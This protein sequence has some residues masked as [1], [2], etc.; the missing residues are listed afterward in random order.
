MKKNKQ[1]KTQYVLVFLVL[2]QYFSIN[3]WAEPNRKTCQIFIADKVFDGSILHVEEPMA[4]V[5]KKRRIYQVVP[6]STLNYNCKKKIDLG[7]ATIMPGLVESHAH[8]SFQNVD[9]TTVLR[10]GVTTA[11]DVGGP[12][13]PASG[14]IGSLRLVNTGPIIQAPGGYPLNL[15]GGHHKD[16]DHSDEGDHHAATIAVVAHD[17]KHAIEHVEHIANSGAVAIKVALE[18]GGEPGAP[19]TEGHGHGGGDGEGPPP[20]E[21]PV[22]PEEVLSAIV[23]KAHEFGLPVIAHVGEQT[24]FD[25]AVSAG[26][27]EFAHIPCAEVTQESITEAVA[28]GMRFQT[29]TNTLSGCLG[30]AANMHKILHAEAHLFDPVEA[31]FLYASEIG[32]DDVPWGFNGQ[33]AINLLLNFAGHTPVDFGHVL[34]V[35]KSATSIPGGLIGRQIGEPLLGTLEPGAPADLIAVKGNALERFK[36]FEYPDLVVSGGENIVNNFQKWH[37]AQ[38]FWYW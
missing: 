31:T 38:K 5:V 4:V 2:F 11:R 6:V 34:R 36:L 37:R 32:H 23:T 25:L 9:H 18:P 28:A 21:W 20:G 33:E 27:D 7:D 1:F 15:F 24:G 12:L 14:G 16:D 29:T 35:I 26:V 17:T 22:L 8:I 19:W 10:H 3:A 13:M 30:I